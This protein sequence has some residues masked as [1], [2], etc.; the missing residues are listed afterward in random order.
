MDSR[1]RRPALRV[2]AALAAACLSCLAT[3]G[4]T[5]ADSSLTGMDRDVDRPTASEASS[6]ASTIRV[7]EVEANAT[8][9]MS[10]FA[11]QATSS[12]SGWRI[13]AEIEAPHGREISFTDGVWRVRLIGGLWEFHPPAKPVPPGSPTREA[14]REIWFATDCVMLFDTYSGASHYHGSEQLTATPPAEPSSLE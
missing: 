12:C 9:T 4:C 11:M 2:K 5:E 10:A 14:W 8:P 13:G 7:T 3:I 6:A 1:K